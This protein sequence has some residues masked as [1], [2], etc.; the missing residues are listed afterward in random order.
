MGNRMMTVNEIWE[1]V[2]ILKLEERNE[3]INR[4]LMLDT[5]TETNEPLHDILEF[6]GIAAHLADEEDPQA[7]V[8]RIRD[9]WDKR[10]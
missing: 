7:Y 2:R 3:L 5:D 8:N 6:E 1:Q 9:E 4:L 10:F